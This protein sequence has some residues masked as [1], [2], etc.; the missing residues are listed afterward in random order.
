MKSFSPFKPV[1]D[2]T[3]AQIKT[4][5]FA[6][7]LRANAANV[8]KPFERSRWRTAR[9]WLSYNDVRYQ[10]K[11][12]R[13]RSLGAITFGSVVMTDRDVETA[14]K[15]E[16]YATRQIFSD[17]IHKLILDLYD[18]D[19][20]GKLTKRTVLDNINTEFIR[21]GRGTVSERSINWKAA[22]RPFVCN[23][24]CLLKPKISSERVAELILELYD[25]GG[26]P[27]HG[28]G[29]LLAAPLPQ[30]NRAETAPR[31]HHPQTSTHGHGK[32]PH[33][34]KPTT[35]HTR[36]HQKV[37]RAP[38]ARQRAHE[39]TT[40][41]RQ[42]QVQNPSQLAHMETR[43]HQNRTQTRL[44]RIRLRGSHAQGTPRRAVR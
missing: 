28:G 29:L 22:I 13:D 33:L 7:W 24:V 39:K 37:L 15:Y 41:R 11:M 4:K 10:L 17:D 34:Q 12:Y 9:P 30:Q 31:I 25:P 26:D 5:T 38:Q 21:L 44:E 19:R 6:M 3:P 32:E 40:V 35:N 43:R 2:G 20:K 16:A 23:S 27:G 18:F 1:Q 8:R 36:H 42:P 14:V